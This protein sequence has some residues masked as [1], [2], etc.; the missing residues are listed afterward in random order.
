MFESMFNYVFINFAKYYL[1]NAS[2]Q[3]K[4]SN[5]ATLKLSKFTLNVC[6]TT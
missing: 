3:Q 4:V 1:E 2:T 6:Y 5:M